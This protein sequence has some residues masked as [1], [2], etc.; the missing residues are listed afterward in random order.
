MESELTPVENIYVNN[1]I[2]ILI[3]LAGLIGSSAWY[4]LRQQKPPSSPIEEHL[5]CSVDEECVRFQ[6]TCN[7]CDCGVAINQEYRAIYQE[8][9]VIR[10]KNDSPDYLCSMFC[11]NIPKCIKNRCVMVERT[12]GPI[13]PA[14]GKAQDDL[15]PAPTAP[16]EPVETARRVTTA[17]SPD[18]SIGASRDG[19]RTTTSASIE[20]SF[21]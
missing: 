16:S 21:S 20:R 15:L 2:L 17:T 11:I 19:R 4:V 12:P 13:L 5:L 8:K 14:A 9:K 18:S 3:I 6:Q 1:K 10:C 7:D